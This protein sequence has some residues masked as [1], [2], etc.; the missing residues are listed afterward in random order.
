MFGIATMLE[1]Q[2]INAF[3]MVKT[4]RYYLIKVNM[5]AKLTFLKIT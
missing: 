1:N 2:R 5:Y 3:P 4:P